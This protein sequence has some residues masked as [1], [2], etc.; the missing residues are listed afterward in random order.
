MKLVIFKKM[1]YTACGVYMNLLERGKTMALITPRSKD[2]SKFK[3]LIVYITD[4]CKDKNSFASTVLNK[5]L[6]Y[7]DFYYYA[8]YGKSI[9]GEPYIKEDFGPIPINIYEARTQLVKEHILEVINAEYYDYRQ[10]KPIVR[11]EYKTKL[12]TDKE[13]EFVDKIIEKYGS[14]NA[15]EISYQSH[16]ETPYIYAR[17]GEEI[18]YFTAK[19]L[20][21]IKVPEEIMSKTIEYLRGI[22]Y[23]FAA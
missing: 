18:P 2:L 8:T 4:K 17:L 11:G 22:G 7:S 15:T 19:M 9:S 10:N 20:G 14:L 3:E 12:L 6:F 13:K 23:Q 1:C 5:L 16:Q 21:D